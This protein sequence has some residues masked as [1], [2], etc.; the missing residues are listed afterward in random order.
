MHNKGSGIMDR[1]DKVIASQSLLSRKE[2]HRLIWT[3][4]VFADGKQVNKIDLKIDPEKTQLTVDGRELKY[5]KYVYIMLNKPKGCVSA[6]TDSEQ[7]TVIDLIPDE[8]RRVGLAPVGRLDKDTTGLL[9]ITDDGDFS[10][11]VTSP[12]KKIFKK[13]IAMLDVSPSEEELDVL[14]N[15]VVIDGGEECLPCRAN[16]VN[17]EDHVMEISIC[18]GKY[19]QVKRMAAAIGKKVLALKRVSIDSLRLDEALEEGECRELTQEEID[20]FL[21]KQ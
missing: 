16:L 2:V 13:Y 11:R 12:R 6:S 8:L 19:H 10:H 18:E 15:G 14:R 20:I 4:K 1:I 7:K 17:D 5:K 9:I 3:G 21:K